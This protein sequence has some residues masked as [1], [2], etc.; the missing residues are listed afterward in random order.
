MS[1]VFATS[2]KNVTRLESL[3]KRLRTIM[4]DES[5]DRAAQMVADE[6]VHHLV[7][8]DASGKTVG[9]LST[10]DVVRALTGRPP[11]HVAASTQKTAI[12][13]EDEVDRTR[14]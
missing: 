14:P 4:V 5:M 8:V 12:G 7:V 3:K 11:K 10:L 1:S 13:D 2:S 6:D 9:M